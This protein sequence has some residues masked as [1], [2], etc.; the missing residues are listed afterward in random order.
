MPSNTNLGSRLFEAYNLEVA[1]VNPTGL[2]IITATVGDIDTRN[3]RF[4]G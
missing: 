1:R 2:G 3:R 4:R